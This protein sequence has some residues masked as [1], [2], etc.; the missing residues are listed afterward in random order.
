VA[1]QLRLREEFARL[2][3]LPRHI[4]LTHPGYIAG[5]ITAFGALCLGFAPDLDPLA[6]SLDGLLALF[7]GVRLALQLFVYDRDLLPATGRP[8]SSSWAPSP[9]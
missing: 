6:L 1:R 8:T 3:V 5:L 2:S 7:W 9:A 4:V